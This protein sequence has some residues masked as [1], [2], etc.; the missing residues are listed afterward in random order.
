MTVRVRPCSEADRR[1]V[2]ALAH[3]LEE[4]VSPWRDRV[5]VAEA[6]RGWVEASVAGAEDGERAS[7]VAEDGDRVVGFVSVERSRHWSG[8]VEAYIGE[9]MVAEDAEGRGIG[10]ALVDEAIR[11]G[12][13]QGLDRIALETGAANTPALGFY[14]G[15]AF[16][17]DE[18]RL[19]RQL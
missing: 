19:S 2:L 11:W 1:S 17:Q 10:R 3:R 15:L 4:G 6:V 16:E 9:L 13:A 14:R 8:A 18:V 12:R 7:F 5:A